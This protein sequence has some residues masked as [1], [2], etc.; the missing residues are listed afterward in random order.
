MLGRDIYFIQNISSELRMWIISCL[1]ILL[2]NGRHCF[3]TDFAMFKNIATDFLMENLVPP[4]FNMMQNPDL[5]AT[6]LLS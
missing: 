1:I 6:V 2:I 5:W 3:L 4:N